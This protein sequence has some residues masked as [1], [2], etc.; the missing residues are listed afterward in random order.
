MSHRE[1]IDAYLAGPQQLRD[2]VAGMSDEQLNAKPIPG[3]M[4][5]KEVVCHLADF[6]PVYADRMKR[7]I[8][9]DNPPLRGGDPD[10]WMKALAYD[11]RNIAEELAVIDSVRAQMGRILHAV[12]E[13]AWSRTGV[14][15]EAG[16]LS[17]EEL[18]RRI[19]NHMPHHIA[20]IEEKR[21]ALARG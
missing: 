1:L 5:T 17:L 9:E 2:A 15:S 20:F 16:P 12:P 14:H 8:A 13:A 7:V 10:V 3:K 11:Q 19:T 21:A 18:L 6:E 4:S